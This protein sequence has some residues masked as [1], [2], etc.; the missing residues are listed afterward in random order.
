MPS[1]EARA[2]HSFFLVNTEP[3]QRVLKD[4]SEGV[5]LDLVN[6]N[7]VTGSFLEVACY[8]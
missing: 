1:L 4:P 7:Q 8:L 3:L 6:H 2:L 5:T